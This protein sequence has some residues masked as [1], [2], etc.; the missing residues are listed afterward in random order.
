VIEIGRLLSL[1]KQR[2]G[3]GHWLAW[4]DAEFGWFSRTA[5]RY[6]GAYEMAGKFDNLSNLGIG[7]STLYALAA[8]S[9]SEAARVQVI[10]RFEA[11]ERPKHNEVQALL[12]M[13]KPNVIKGAAKILHAQDAEVRYAERTA[14]LIEISKRNA[15]LPFGCEFVNLYADPAY[16]FDMTSCGNRAIENH[17]PTLSLEEICALEVPRVTAPA[18]VLF[19]WVPTP[20]MM[21]HAPCILDAWGF[22]YRSAIAWDKEVPGMGF[23]VREQ[24][25][26]LLIATKGDMPCPLP[27]NRPRSIIRARRTEHSVKPIEAY[28]IIEGMYPGD[29]P[30]LEL[31]ARGPARQGWATWGNEAETVVGSAAPK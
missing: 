29:L 9:T 21:T 17:C 25:E 20:L 12:A 2:C 26:H 6:I 13:H 27:A 31:F 10:A 16:R 4:L 18:A 24:H 30:R 5:E 22:H 8:P 23:W 3:H 14:K 19:L 11:G 7:L 15:P 1:C 28:E